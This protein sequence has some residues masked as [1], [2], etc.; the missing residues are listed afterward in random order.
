VNDRRTPP[1]RD[2]RRATAQDV[3]QAAGVSRA[4][5]SFVLNDTPGQTIPESTRLRVL[6]AAKRLDYRPNNAA[7]RSSVGEAGS[8]CF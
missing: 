4:T 5:V 6:A 3:A 2:A 8:S 7:G 1:P